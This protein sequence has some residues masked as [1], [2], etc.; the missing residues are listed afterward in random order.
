MDHDYGRFITSLHAITKIDLSLYKEGQMKRRL[1]AFRN[2]KNYPDF[3]AFYKA[4]VKDDLLLEEL[5]DRITI[6]VSEFYRNPEC[7]ETLRT[8]IL[9]AISSR[10]HKIKV[11]SAACSTGEEPYTL[12][13]ILMESA[14]QSS[15]SIL[16]SD[17]DPL[18]L[19]KA[20]EGQYGESSLKN[21][22]EHVKKSSF[23]QKNQ[24]FFIRDAAKRHITFQ[25]HNLLADPYA[26][27]YDLIVCRNVMIY[28]TDEAKEHL[29]TKFA[30]ALRPGGFLF[31]GSTE[32]IFH[33]E[34]F[35]LKAYVPFVYQKVDGNSRNEKHDGLTK[36]GI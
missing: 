10:T 16:A 15:F 7:W 22:P 32:Q 12:A 9:P 28:F 14:S 6:N 11:W 17:L 4:L 3:D 36:T 26:K 24:T 29:Y 5:L 31:V 34:R 1:T 20:E 33:P 19:K 35:S 23:I 13:T 21:V 27:D 2:K 8:Q 25:R 18:V 30:E